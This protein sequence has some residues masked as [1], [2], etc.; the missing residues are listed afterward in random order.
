[1]W[2][3]RNLGIGVAESDQRFA[4]PEAVLKAADKILYKAKNKGRNRVES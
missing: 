4:D 3:V 2:E 1:M